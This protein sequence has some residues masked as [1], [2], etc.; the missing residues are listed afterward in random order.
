[1]I[2]QEQTVWTEAGKIQT[3]VD[4]AADLSSSVINKTKV[5]GA[6]HAGHFRLAGDEQADLVNH[7]GPNKAILEYAPTHYGAGVPSFLRLTLRPV[8]VA[9]ISRLLILTNRPAKLRKGRIR[10]KQFRR[11][12]S[13]IQSVGLAEIRDP[14]CRPLFHV[15][16][17]H[18]HSLSRGFFN[19][20]TSTA[21]PQSTDFSTA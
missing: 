1:M 15:L 13:Q 12:T 9:R 14:S 8:D 2:T 11:T 21:R 6:A 4:A 18:C 7:G 10:F 5:S 17:N 20:P 16:N 19:A 3:L